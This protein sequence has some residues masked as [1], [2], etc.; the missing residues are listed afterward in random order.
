MGIMAERIRVSNRAQALSFSIANVALLR[1]AAQ[2]ATGVAGRVTQA[3]VSQAN[4]FDEVLSGSSAPD[5]SSPSTPSES[6]SVDA[7]AAQRVDLTRRLASAIRLELAKHSIDLNQRLQLSVQADGSLRVNPVN[8]QS[9][10]IEALLNSDPA[11]LQLA[12]ELAKVTGE[13]E[14]SVDLTSSGEAEKIR[15]PG[16][17]PNW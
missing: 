15:V 2:L 14:I 8:G 13:R 12:G 1:G 7:A 3:M 10:Q 11:T 16:G 5:S 6:A 4:G 9:A 17:Y